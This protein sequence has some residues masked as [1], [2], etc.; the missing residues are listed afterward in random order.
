MAPIAVG[1]ETD[2]SLVN[3]ST[4]AS[5]YTIKPTYGLVDTTNIIPTS[6]RY[7]TADPMGKSVKDVA[8]LLSVLVD[9]SK[10]EVS[11]G[12]YASAMTTTWNDIRVGTLDP[13]QWKMSDDFVKPA[14][15]ATKQIVRLGSSDSGIAELTFF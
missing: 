14:P 4:R 2:G 6:S 1:T 7:D 5:L 13:E 9:H 11:Q 10:T 12:G 15:Q 3:P 8:D